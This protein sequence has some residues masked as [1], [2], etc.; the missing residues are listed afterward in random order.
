MVS[1]IEWRNPLLLGVS[2]LQISEWFSL[3]NWHVNENCQASHRKRW[4]T[5]FTPPTIVEYLPCHWWKEDVTFYFVS[6]AD[7]N[8]KR[9]AKSQNLTRN[10]HQKRLIEVWSMHKSPALLLIRTWTISY[11]WALVWGKPFALYLFVLRCISLTASVS[12]I[13]VHMLPSAAGRSYGEVLSC[14][15]IWSTSSTPFVHATVD[16]AVTLFER[17]LWATTGYRGHTAMM[18]CFM[19]VHRWCQA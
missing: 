1:Y 14:E 17:S 2:L 18:I 4:I 13:W 5:S 6:I 3:E 12:D 11:H 16:D 19:L 9:H 8:R 15:H 10:H 7:I